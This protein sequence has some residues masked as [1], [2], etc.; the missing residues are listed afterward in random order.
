[1]KSF[2]LSNVLGRQ[3]RV[4]GELYGVRDPSFFFLPCHKWLPFPRSTHGPKWLL[5]LQSFHQNSSKKERVR[6]EIHAPSLEAAYMTS[7]YIP[8][9]RT[10]SREPD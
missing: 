7:I 8:L 1:M 4:G 9:A 10:L 2:F 5:G 6:E 3:P